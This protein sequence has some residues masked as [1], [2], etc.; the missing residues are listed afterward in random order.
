MQDFRSL[1]TAVI[2]QQA[3]CQEAYTN[4]LQIKIRNLLSEGMTRWDYAILSVVALAFFVANNPLIEPDKGH[5]PKRAQSQD[6]T[7]PAS[8]LFHFLNSTNLNVSS[9][10][11]PGED[12]F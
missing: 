1:N 10:S 2:E 11:A 6:Q 3:K 4:V 5:R 12:Q 9:F 7:D 8:Q